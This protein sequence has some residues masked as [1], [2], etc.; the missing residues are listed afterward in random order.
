[1]NRVALITLLAVASG[2]QVAAQSGTLNASDKAFLVKDSR[3]AAYELASAK[4]AVQ[5]ASRNDIKGYAE[6][7]VKDHEDYNTALESLGQQDG[8]TLPT[9]PDTADKAHMAAL[10]K[11]TG[12]AF[13]RLYVREALRINAEDK[14]DAEKEKAATK[15]EAVRAFIAKFADMDAEHER[16]AKQLAHSP[17]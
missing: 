9:E 1:M 8:I 12:K 7:L 10:Q 5:K 2:G 17:G 16:L 15:S 11:L 4:L 13:D 6:K 3:G 14:R